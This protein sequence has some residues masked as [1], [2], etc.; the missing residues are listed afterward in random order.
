[1]RFAKPVDTAFWLDALVADGG[2]CDLGC[3]GSADELLETVG[4]KVTVLCGFGDCCELWRFDL[5]G[6]TSGVV[7]VALEAI[8]ILVHVR[9]LPTTRHHG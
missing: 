2:S 4:L 5:G 8:V 7:S 9:I 1:M 3:D 6:V